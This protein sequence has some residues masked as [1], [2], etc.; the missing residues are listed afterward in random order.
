MKPGRRRASR[1]SSR[2]EPDTMPL[3]EELRATF[4][5]RWFSIEEAEKVTDE[6]PAFLSNSHL[7][8]RTLIPAEGSGVL[9]VDRPSGCKARAFTY[10]VRMRFRE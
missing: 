4:K 9:E 5:G 8:M 2:P 3:L 6:T 10:G 7:K 1:C